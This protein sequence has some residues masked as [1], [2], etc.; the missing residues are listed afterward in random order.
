MIRHCLTWVE[1]DVERVEDGGDHHIVIGRARTLGEVLQDKPLLFYRGGYLSTEHPRVHPPRRNSRNSSPGTAPTPGCRGVHRNN[2]QRRDRPL[3]AAIAEA[4]KLITSSRIHRHGH[5]P[6]RRLGLP[7]R[8]HRR[9]HPAG[10]LATAL[11]PEL[12]HLDG[13]VR[14]MGLDNPDTLYYH[15]DIQTRRNLRGPRNTRENTVDLSFQIL[16]GDYTA[17][18][19]PGGDDAFDDRRITIADDGSFTLTFGPDPAGER[20]DNYFVLGDGASMLAVRD[21]YGDWTERKGSIS[22][23]R[24]DTRG[25]APEEPDVAKVSRR[26]SVAGKM[27]LAHQHLV[28]LPKWFY[29]DEPVNTFTPPR[30]T[31]GGLRP[32]LIGRSLP[33]RRR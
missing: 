16:R 30:L 6:R 22:I 20:P 10:T 14:K 18:N 32:V 15:A 7:G 23:Q 33:A 19:V 26:F 8:Q 1:C 29:L 5:R 12:R 4:E 17:T 25:T 31:P 9:G 28:Q 11:A 21:V 3:A 13:P 27:L 24:V 2:V